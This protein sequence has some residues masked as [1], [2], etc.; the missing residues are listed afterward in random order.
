MPGCPMPIVAPE[1]LAGERPDIVVVMNPIY[2]DEITAQLASMNLT[3]TMLTAEDDPA[4]ET[5]Q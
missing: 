2:R 3:P 5:P 4:E 1:T